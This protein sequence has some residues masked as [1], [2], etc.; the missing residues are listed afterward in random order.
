VLRQETLK[1]A[2]NV[3]KVTGETLLHTTTA[4]RAG[5]VRGVPSRGNKKSTHRKGSNRAKHRT[6]DGSHRLPV[7]LEDVVADAAP[8]A[9]DDRPRPDGMQEKLRARVV[10]SVVRGKQDPASQDL[11]PGN[12]RRL[13]GLADVRR[14]QE[15]G[16]AP[17]KLQDEGPLV[18]LAV[19][20]AR[21]FFPLGGGGQLQIGH[22]GQLCRLK[23]TVI[24]TPAEYTKNDGFRG[25]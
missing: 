7:P 25:Q 21:A 2:G 6:E 23:T 10:G 13:G 1:I 20:E 19:V 9:D 17:S 12:E 3:T 24:Y 18:N 4:R 22:M 8:R 5:L 11:V 14:E 15:G 16:I